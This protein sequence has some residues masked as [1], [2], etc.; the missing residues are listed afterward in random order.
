MRA[1]QQRYASSDNIVPITAPAESDISEILMLKEKCERRLGIGIVL[2]GEF[3]RSMD[4]EGVGALAF[5]KNARLVGFIFFYSFDKEEV[6]ASLFADPDDDWKDVGSALLEAMREESRRR[7]YERLL[8]M[9]DRRFPSGAQMIM[10]RGGKPAFSEHRMEADDVRISTSHHIDL[11]LVGNDDA[12][13]I[14]VEQACHGRF[15]SK[16]D[17]RRYLAIHEGEVI[18]KIDVLAEGSTA[19]LTGFCVIPE[20]RGRGYGKAI[21]QTIIRTMRAEGMDRIILDVQTDNDIALSLYL[22]SGFRKDFTLDYYA[23]PLEDMISHEH[24]STIQ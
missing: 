3:L 20:Q 8:V 4:K 1:D 10:E 5:K 21:L 17:Q 12:S 13:L 19:D 6:E 23:I 11:C 22:K 7:G 14:A 24:H 18:G 9:N 15:Y 16:P 2:G